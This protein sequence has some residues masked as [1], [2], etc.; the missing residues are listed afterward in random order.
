MIPQT[1]CNHGIEVFH[2]MYNTGIALLPKLELYVAEFVD[3]CHKW[4][5]HYLLA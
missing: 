1:I 4:Q 2:F 3:C 5:T